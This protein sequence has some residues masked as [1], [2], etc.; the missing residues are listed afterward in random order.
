[1]IRFITYD[2]PSL[3]NDIEIY[4]KE[5]SNFTFEIV[6][7]ERKP[8]NIKRLSNVYINLFLENIPNKFKQYYPA[9]YN[10]FMPNLEFFRAYNEVKYINIILCKTKE[11]YDY[12]QSYALEHNCNF[13][14][15]YTKFYSI[16]PSD[17]KPQE[18]NSNLFI[19]LAGNSFFKNVEYVVECWIKYKC[20]LEYDPLIELH[21]TCYNMCWDKVYPQIKDKLIITDRIIKYNNLYIYTKRPEYEYYVKL[22]ST[23]NM[24]ICISRK[25]GYGHYINEA[26]YFNTW[27]ISMDNPPMNELVIDKVN[28]SLL[29]DKTNYYPQ[30]E[31]NTKWKLYNAIPN[32]DE[33]AEHIIHCIK[34]KA[35]INKNNLSRKMFD[36]DKEY[37]IHKMKSIITTLKN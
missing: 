10:L 29:K 11:A 25:E 30:R 36:D 17:I 20:F 7:M 1:M 22:L 15:H 34:H 24:S 18:K 2:T 27:I 3:H 26:R 16:V 37:F 5:F 28:G 31:G 32:I 35:T 12:F 8:K 9:K 4:K 14:C 6:I 19:C 23:A 33:L 13:T 21:I